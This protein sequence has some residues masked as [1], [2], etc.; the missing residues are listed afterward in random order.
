LRNLAQRKSRLFDRFRLRRV[1]ET[2]H[3]LP[4][5]AQVEINRNG[6]PYREGVGLRMATRDQRVLLA[7]IKPVA[8]IWIYKISGSHKPLN[9][10]QKQRNS[11]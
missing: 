1:A 3:E 6:P 10:M 9:F 4:L 7:F 5:T 8:F 11:C 2:R